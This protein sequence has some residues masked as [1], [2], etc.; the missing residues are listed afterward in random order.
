[1][2]NINLTHYLEFINE[3]DKTIY[4]VKLDKY[5]DYP[6][7]MS[8]LDDDKAYNYSGG[9]FKGEIDLSKENIKQ[10]NYTIKIIAYNS[11][12][13]KTET[14]FTNIAYE[15]MPRRINTKTRGISF[16]VDYSLAGSPILVSIRDEG[17]ISYTEPTS[18]DPT[19]NFFNELKIANNTLNITGTSHSAYVN[20]SKNDTVKRSII[21]EN[22]NTFKR[23]IY[24]LS[25]IDNGPY[26]I[27]LSVSDNKDKTRAWF[28]KSI[29]LSNLD[30]G[31]YAIYINTSSNDKTYYGELIDIAY[32]DFSSINTDK[33]EFKRIDEKRLRLELSVK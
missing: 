16:D 8:S 14:Y 4:K 1:M 28:K 12:G 27:E 19:Y 17:L 29:D 11:N 13:Y 31:T 10:G 18:M 7:E 20:Y 6:Y 2:D 33:Y 5:T 25:Y 30:K 22:T 26:K 15:E 32:T 9:W 3:Y 21:F 24:D 23:Y